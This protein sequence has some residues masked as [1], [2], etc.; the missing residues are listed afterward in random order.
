[1]SWKFSFNFSKFQIRLNAEDN[2]RI[3]VRATN[4]RL[5]EIGNYDDN[6]NLFFKRG[7]VEWAR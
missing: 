1:M 4:A 2:T 6:P 3:F 7:Q 5:R